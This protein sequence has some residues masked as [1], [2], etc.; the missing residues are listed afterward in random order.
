MNQSAPFCTH[1]A[2]VAT[3]QVLEAKKDLFCTQELR[4]LGSG[5]P[6]IHNRRITTVIPSSICIILFISFT[7]CHFLISGR[8]AN[9]RPLYTDYL[10]STSAHGNISISALI[11]QHPP[12]ILV[13]SFLIPLLDCVSFL[14]AFSH[15]LPFLWSTKS[16]H[17]PLLF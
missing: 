11:H 4:A 12:K 9:H 14:F 15:Q 1:M 6:A 7:P 5:L 10:I 16:H 17:F 2:M 3:S 13:W 8:N